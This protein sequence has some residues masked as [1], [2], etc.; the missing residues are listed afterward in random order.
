M[1]KLKKMMDQME[2]SADATQDFVKNFEAPNSAYQYAIEKA[3]FKDRMLDP[4]EPLKNIDFTNPNLASEFRRRLMEWI[5]DFDAA[6]DDEHEVGIH[7]VSFGRAVSFHFESIGYYNPSLICFT[8]KLENG[9]PVE[10]IQHVSQISIMLVKMKWQ[11][12][13]QPKRRIGFTEKEE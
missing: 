9:D 12:P 3:A 7:L 10:L 11:D 8:G 4:I 1:D 13:S 2:K 5:I 6:L